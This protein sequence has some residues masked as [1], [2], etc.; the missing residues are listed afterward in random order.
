[1]KSNMLS[2]V[3]ETITKLGIFGTGSKKDYEEAI[4]IMKDKDKEW[5]SSKED[6]NQ[7]VK[8][9]SYFITTEAGEASPKESGSIYLFER[10][11]YILALFKKPN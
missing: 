3:G 4:R 10:V 7:A 6:N 9:I 8:Y 1:M 11:I 2:K 5:K